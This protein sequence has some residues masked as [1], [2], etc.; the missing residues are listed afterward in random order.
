MVVGAASVVVL[1]FFAAFVYVKIDEALIERVVN[2]DISHRKINHWQSGDKLFFTT[3]IENKSNIEWENVGISF[4]LKK[5]NGSFFKRC[6]TVL[7]NPPLGKGAMDVEVVCPY[8]PN[9]MP[10]FTYVVE[11]IGEH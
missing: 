9:P 7:F 1:V 2:P 11:I 8:M 3:V 10:E 6:E 5:E 4:I